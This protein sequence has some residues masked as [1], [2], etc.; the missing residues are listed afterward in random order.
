MECQQRERLWREYEQ[1]L[2]TLCNAVDAMKESSLTALSS[3]IIARNA[4]QKLCVEARHAWEAHLRE[5]S[6]DANR[7]YM[8]A[9]SSY[10]TDY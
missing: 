1:A 5:H 10:S 3:S 8:T 9:G 6:C 4:A 2:A 7:K